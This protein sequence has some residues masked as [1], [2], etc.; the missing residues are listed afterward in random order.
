MHGFK[1]K[2]VEPPIHYNVHQPNILVRTRKIRNRGVLV[3]CKLSERILDEGVAGSVSGNVVGN[4]KRYGSTAYRMNPIR[5]DRSRLSV[6]VGIRV[7]NNRRLVNRRQR[8]VTRKQRQ[9]LIINSR[10]SRWTKT[11]AEQKHIGRGRPSK[12]DVTV[13]KVTI[14]DCEVARKT[15]GGKGRSEALGSPSINGYN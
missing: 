12:R 13:R 6:G 7:G 11:V 8:L 4:G 1:I 15:V 10:K 9:A 14:R 3:T 5:I 2:A